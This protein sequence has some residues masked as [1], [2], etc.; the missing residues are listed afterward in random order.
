MTTGF[1]G[2]SEFDV[3]LESIGLEIQ[4]E[5]QLHLP[6][7]KS[8]LHKHVPSHLEVIPKCS[9][10]LVDV[11]NNKL[12]NLLVQNKLLGHL[13]DQLH[14]RVLQRLILLR[15]FEVVV[16]DDLLLEETHELVDLSRDYLK[17]LRLDCSLD[18][19]LELSKQD[20]ERMLTVALNRLL[21]QL[22]LL[23][24]HKLLLGLGQDLPYGDNMVSLKLK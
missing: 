12:S 23:P 10:L 5:W 18:D 20:V 3:L 24:E 14:L 21:Y 16:P 13:L 2:L 4:L 22:Q 7:L 9:N 17:V 11:L 1:N 8:L 15:L 6:L 19:A